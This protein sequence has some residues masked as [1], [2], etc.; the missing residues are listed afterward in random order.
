MVWH[1]AAL[2]ANCRAMSSGVARVAVAIGTGVRFPLCLA[3]QY[4]AQAAGA[5]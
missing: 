5:V 4:D 1:G 3:A 2:V